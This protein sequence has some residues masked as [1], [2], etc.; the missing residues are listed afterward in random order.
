MRLPKNWLG[1]DKVLRASR[2]LTESTPHM[3]LL[4]PR[5]VAAANAGARH[6]G[7]ITALAKLDNPEQQKTQILETLGDLDQYQ[8]LDDECLIAVYAESNV[9][10]RIT[11]ATGKTVELVGTDSRTTES[12][13][14]GKVGLLVKIGP[15][16]FTYHNNGQ[17]Y[18]GVRPEVG[19][20]VVSHASDGREI[21]LR[22]IDS[23]APWVTCRRIKWDRIVMRV[24]DP[25]VV[26]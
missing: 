25:R 18:A 17:A 13:Y 8:L 11:D 14:Q 2:D 12:R 16:A 10:S 6:K 19:D 1:T 20:W 26:H 23:H 9:L 3:A 5:H 15:T 21:W 4:V 7:N 24:T 22:G